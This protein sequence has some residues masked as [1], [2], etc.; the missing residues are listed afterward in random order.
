MSQVKDQIN[1][2]EIMAEI[3]DKDWYEQ[4]ISPLIGANDFKHLMK[5]FI[6]VSSRIIQDRAYEIFAHQYYLF[7]IEDGCDLEEYLSIMRQTIS[8]FKLFDLAEGVS[9]SYLRLPLQKDKEKMYRDAEINYSML[10]RKGPKVVCLDI[11]EWLSELHTPDFKRFLINLESN[12]QKAV[13]VFRIPYLDTHSIDTAYSALSDVLTVRKVLFPPLSME[14]LIEYAKKKLKEHHFEADEEVWRSFRQRIIR[15]KN[16]GKFYEKMT[17][18]KLVRELV[19]KKQCFDAANDSCS[20]EIHTPEIAGF[21]EDS[22]DIGISAKAMMEKLTGLEEIKKQIRE[23]TKTIAYIKKGRSL[24]SPCIHMRFSG[25]PGTG[26][27]TV[28]RIVGKLLKEKGV[29][30]KGDFFEVSGRDLCGSY[31]GHTTPLTQRICRDAFGSILFID[32]AYSLYSKGASDSDFGKEAL[33][34]L[35]SEMENHRD[36][37]VVIMAGYNDEMNEL[38]EANPGLLSRMP[39]MIEFPNYTRDQLIEIFMSMIPPEIE[40]GEAFTN[41]VSQFF[42]NISEDTLNRK[43]FSN[44][45][46][47]RNLFEMTLSKAIMRK[48]NDEGERLDLIPIDFEL[49]SQSKSIAQLVGSNERRHV[50]F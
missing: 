25:N 20:Y 18:D 46:F 47:V 26:K 29:L 28:A 42:Y 15:E 37:F 45:R 31:I 38:M 16:E 12:Y 50:G 39:Y 5:E 17:I 1:N 21:I 19:Y 14:Q 49:A 6:T 11:S 36:D 35:M 34:T 9:A 33:I 41:T 22:T 24:E 3:S 32:E 40:F 2:P 44:A 43:E 48:E 23:I 10:F 7:A 30:S 4:L 27:T 8:R 13:V